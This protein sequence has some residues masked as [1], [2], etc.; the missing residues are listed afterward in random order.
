MTDLEFQDWLKSG[1]RQV[2][3]VEVSTSVPKYLSTVPYSTLPTDTPSNRLYLPIIQGG[4]AFSE[5]L[6]LSGG[7]SLSY[8]DIEIN[9]QDGIYDTW[10]DEIWD[11]KKIRVL[12]GDVSW[13]YSDFRIL[14][15]G[16]VS[17][18]QSQS[19]ST[20]NITVR[21]KLQRLNTSVTETVLGGT[22]PNKDRLRP[23]VLGEVHNI[24]PLLVDPANHE[25]QC[26]NGTVERLIEVR[27]DGV[28]RTTTT[29]GVVY[30]GSFR[31]TAAPV[32]TITASVQGGSPYTNT[33]AGIVQ[34][35]ATSYGTPSERFSSSDLDTVQLAAFNTANPQP[36]GIY[37]SE[38]ANVL[39]VCQD[40][41][42]SVGA[43]LSM[44]R[45]GKLR[46][47]KIDLPA[48]G[49]PTVIKMSDYEAGSFSLSERTDV[50]SGIRLGY[51]KN[52]TVQT[53]ID[54]GIPSEHKDLYAQEWLTRYDRD[55]TVAN[56][57]K[58]YG[59][60]PQ[61]DTYLLKGSDAQAEATR[62]L[63]LWKVQRNVFKFTGYANLLTLEL[64]QT[65]TIFNDRFGLSEGKTGQVIGLSSDWINRRVEVE[66]IV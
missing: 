12:V 22:T 51:C 35:L 14:L 57:Y 65:V 29:S 60:I 13:N 64:G 5:S 66:V 62:R 2:I 21:D 40:V 23:I 26:H 27:A 17:K 10:L 42:N 6:S 19:I 20:L 48:T 1:G 39:Q 52:W 43:Q 58:L 37:L 36:V 61:T 50:V 55:S 53:N 9:N 34:V 7:A 31:L 28:P 54:S 45:Q 25:Y 18:L 16:V 44:T 32:G 33:V 4:V 24:E 11:N 8:G 3:L 38:R 63:S 49:T 46:L 56:N 30:P 59:E 47:L 15:D 41:A